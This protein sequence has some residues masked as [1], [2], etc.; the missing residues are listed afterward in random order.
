M[1][2][3]TKRVNAANG[4]SSAKIPGSILPFYVKRN[5]RQRRKTVAR[6]SRCRAV[7][8]LLPQAFAYLSVHSLAV[9]MACDW[10]SFHA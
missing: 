10:F 7:V 9:A 2:R 4:Q 1:I 5:H 3:N 6:G 8:G